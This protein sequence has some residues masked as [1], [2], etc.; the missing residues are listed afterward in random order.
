MK[1]KIT[2]IIFFLLCCL[3]VTSCDTADNTV[4]EYPDWQAK[5]SKFFQNLLDSIDKG[6]KDKS[7]EKILT[8]TK[9]DSGNVSSTDYIIVHK[10]HLGESGNCPLYTDSAKVQYLGRLLPSTSYPQGAIFDQTGTGTK[11]D[12]ATYVPTKFAVSSVVVGFSTALQHMHKGDWWQIY[13]PYTL[14]YGES[15]SSGIPGYSTLIFELR[16]VDFWR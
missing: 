1:I 5:N 9:T 7:W 10:L 16:L 13:I 6:Q 2:H 14:A 12:P 11:L 4:E 15:G 8:W 3:F